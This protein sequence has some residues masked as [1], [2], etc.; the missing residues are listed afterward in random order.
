MIRKAFFVAA[1]S[2]FTCV[3]LALPAAEAGGGM[4]FGSGVSVCR[5]VFNAP[6]QPQ[7]V[8]LT[9]NFSVNDVV[10]VGALALLCDLPVVEART[11]SGPSTVPL[12]GTPT[13]VACYLVGGAEPVRAPSTVT[14]PFTLVTTN[15]GEPQPQNVTIGAVH[16]LCLPAIIP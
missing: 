16:L 12:D 13:A 2:T 9:D 11:I 1:L 14:D 10:N 4:G 6:N 3:T 8:S 15:G 5:L 7:S